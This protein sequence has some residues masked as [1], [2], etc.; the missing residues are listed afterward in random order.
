MKKSYFIKIEDSW[1][2]LYEDIPGNIN[3]KVGNTY[4]VSNELG[5]YHYHT[6]TTEDEIKSFNNK[7]EA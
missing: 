1:W 6:L 3:F 4:K 2:L 7:W 5:G